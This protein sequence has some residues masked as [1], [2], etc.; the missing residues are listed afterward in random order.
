M[1]RST[2]A[3]VLLL[4]AL[5]PSPARAQSAPPLP[6]RVPSA[7][8][9][10]GNL[11]GSGGQI[12]ADLVWPVTLFPIAWEAGGGCHWDGLCQIAA[13]FQWTSVSRKPPAQSRGMFL[14]SRVF[15]LAIPNDAGGRNGYGVDVG[16]GG[17]LGLSK[18]G[19]LRV[20][21]GYAHVHIADDPIRAG[22][23]GHGFTV[24]VQIG[25]DLK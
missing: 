11:P 1:R 21:V 6:T 17:Q 7:W 10:G 5:W 13:G 8:I 4:L 15:V 16:V 23:I 25:S 22:F 2:F 14:D 18:N 9:G 12:T 24:V 3:A 20:R 19:A